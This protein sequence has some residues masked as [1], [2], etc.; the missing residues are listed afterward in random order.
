MVKV[1]G[2]DTQ[3]PLVITESERA[4]VRIEAARKNL[5]KFRD[6]LEAQFAAARCYQYA[7]T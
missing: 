3:R 5:I 2:E 7:F 6:R 4:L 1:A